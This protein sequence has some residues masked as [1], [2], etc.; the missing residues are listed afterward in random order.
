EQSQVDLVASDL[1]FTQMAGLRILSH[2]DSVDS[3][4]G[5][6]W[7]RT[8]SIDSSWAHMAALDYLGQGS[9]LWNDLDSLRR[10]MQSEMQL[11]DLVVGSALTV[12]TGLAVGYVVWM[13]R[14][15]LLISSL[16]AQMPA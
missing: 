1:F 10:Q 8:S 2:R 4:G 7:P 9:F 16:L 12:S 6:S 3:T 14:G 5:N 15:G 11:Q 13:L